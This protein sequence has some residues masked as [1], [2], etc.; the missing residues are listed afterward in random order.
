MA[1]KHTHPGT[2]T[3]GTVFTKDQAKGKLV[4]LGYRYNSDLY[5]WVLPSGEGGRLEWTPD[6]CN[7]NNFNGG[8]SFQLR[9]PLGGVTAIELA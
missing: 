5:I 4:E 2:C 6:Y 3:T 1:K 9:S 8:T 7:P